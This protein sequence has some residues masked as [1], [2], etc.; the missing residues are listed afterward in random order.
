MRLL[1]ISERRG[2]EAA[3]ERQ[4]EGEIKE[5]YVSI[6]NRENVSENHRHIINVT[7]KGGSGRECVNGNAEHWYTTPTDQAKTETKNVTRGITCARGKALP[8]PKKANREI[9]RTT[10]VHDKKM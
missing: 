8:S 5:A 1:I 3:K 2:N 4:E 9:D 7:S 6:R 10:A